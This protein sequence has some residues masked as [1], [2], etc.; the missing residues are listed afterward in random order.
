MDEP[1]VEMRAVELLRSRPDLLEKSELDRL[2]AEGR[3]L[4]D[5]LA[6]AR[7]SSTLSEHERIEKKQLIHMLLDWLKRARIARAR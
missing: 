1:S 3:R 2:I 4:V 7:L 6:D 5:L